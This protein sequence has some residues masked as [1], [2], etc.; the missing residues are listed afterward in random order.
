MI[1][2]QMGGM[3]LALTDYTMFQV[4]EDSNKQLEIARKIEKSFPTDFIY[5][6]DFGTI[7]QHTLG[8]PMKKPERDF[9]STIENPIKT[10]ED[11]EKSPLINVYKDGLFP[12]YLKAISKISKNVEKPQ[13]IACVGPLTLACE[14][15]GLEYVLR[16]TVKNKEY[17][18]R[19]LRYAKVLI[20]DFSRAAIENGAFILQISEPVM[21]ILRPSVYREQVFPFLGELMEEINY[22]AVSALHVCGDTRQYLSI[23]AESKAQIL[24][25]DQ[26]MDMEEAMKQ[27]PSDVAVAGNL[28][29]VEIMLQ[30]TY[31]TVYS[32]AFDL[33]NKMSRYDNFMISFGCDCPIA[34]PIE[35]IKAVADAAKKVRKKRYEE[36]TFKHSACRECSTLIGRLQR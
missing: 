24:S 15:G 12:E 2:P 4:Y 3:G 18:N 5:P 9:P 31:D 28:D 20:S 32:A 10:I 35:S 27:I 29:P 17:V 36:K 1:Y 34:T 23:M 7:F 30:G 6:V 8:F 25:L 33:I 14:L 13:M 21:S 11:I 26:V 22:D 16:A 19:L